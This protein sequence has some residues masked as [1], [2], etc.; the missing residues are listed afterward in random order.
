MESEMPTSNH[1]RASAHA[2]LA[3]GIVIGAALGIPTGAI[4]SATSAIAAPTVTEDSPA[5][6]CIFDGNRICGPGNPQ[7][8][9]AGCYNDRGALVAPW[10]C[11]LV[12]N[13]DGSADV[14]TGSA[15]TR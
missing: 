13:P 2:I 10:P 4:V 11:H 14:Y 6:D 3:A 8:V 1:R 12:V 9:A 5:W 15:V 7:G